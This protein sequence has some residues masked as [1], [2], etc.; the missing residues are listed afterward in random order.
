MES[1]IQYQR[2]SLLIVYGPICIERQR[3]L[4]CWCLKGIHWFQLHHSHQASV[5]V[6]ILMSKFI[7]V[8]DLFRSINIS[9]IADVLCGHSLRMLVF[10]PTLIPLVCIF[11]P[12]NLCFGSWT[13]WDPFC[14]WAVRSA[15][16]IHSLCVS[17]LLNLPKYW[18]NFASVQ[19]QIC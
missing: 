18:H 8:L 15:I 11:P 12:R 4:S 10:W 3:W 5:S 17:K 14:S 7:W 13:T 9:V 1:V 16:G 19:V 2:K 6:S